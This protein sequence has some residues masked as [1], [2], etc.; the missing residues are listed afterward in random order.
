MK[1]SK[2]YIIKRGAKY[3][4]GYSRGLP[5]FSNSL[6]DAEI[7]EESMAQA[8]VCIMDKDVRVVAVEVRE[9]Q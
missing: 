6:R 3:F 2:R 8:S 4:I 5:C 1:A 9:L 7:L